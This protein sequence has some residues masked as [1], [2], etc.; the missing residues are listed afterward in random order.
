MKKR[1]FLLPF[2]FCSMQTMAQSN[3]YNLIIG[4]YTNTG[5][6]EGIYVY[7]FDTKTA[8]FRAKSITK[9]VVN[10]SYLTVSKDNAFVYAVSED[11]A[12]SSVSAFS[13]DAVKGSMEPLNK[14]ATK[15]ADPC[16]V[17]ADELN[18]LTANYSGGSISVFG[19]DSSGAVTGPK[20]IV[21][22]SGGSIDKS[23][24]EGPHV[25]Q[26]RFS[27]DKKYV[28]SNDLGKDKIY[29][30]KYNPNETSN[31]L[32]AHDS[33]SVKAGT[34]PRH[35]TFSKDGKF[36]YLLT[37]MGGI[38][39]VYSYKDG[40]LS[41]LQ[42]AP[43]FGKDLKGE[44]GAADIH[45]TPDG[46]FLY[47]TNRANAN[48]ITRFAVQANGKLLKKSEIPTQGK[49]P[50]NFAI[51]PTGNYLLVAH[52]YTNDVVIFKINKETGALTDTGKRIELGA[53]VCLVFAPVK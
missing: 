32:V 16:F 47:T 15:G 49:G 29:V 11:G 28:I 36:A 9:N 43:I 42:E 25:H 26:V 51:D 27:P 5:K 38:V 34:G 20:Q 7:D 48:S 3:E 52:Q 13:F 10:P 17:I 50:R 21:Q 31:V 4:T 24:Q 41:L 12:N 40:K 1:L 19:R 22:H 46:K 39:N 44:N 6:S 45:L 30:Y 2:L 18:V 35:I 8:A 33:V 53:P 23:R 14:L 37:E